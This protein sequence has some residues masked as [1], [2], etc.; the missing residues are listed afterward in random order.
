[1]CTHLAHF[2]NQKG[3]HSQFKPVRKLGHGN[4]ASVYEVIRV[5]D[6]RRFAVKAFAKGNLNCAEHGIEALV[7]ELEIMRLLSN[8]SCH[9]LSL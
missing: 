1:M 5:E 6:S 7:N 4:F 2:L 3:F 9:L 8:R